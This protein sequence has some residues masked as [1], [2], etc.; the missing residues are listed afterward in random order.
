MS[1]QPPKRTLAQEI[2]KRKTQA[3]LRDLETKRASSSARTT[4]PVQRLSPA[5]TTPK[6]VAPAGFI[7][8][9][10]KPTQTVPPQPKTRRARREQAILVVSGMLV[11]LVCLGTAIAA[12][13]QPASP[14]PTFVPLPTTDAMNVIDY[15]RRVGVPVSNVQ[16]MQVPNEAWNANQQIQF[17]VRRQNDT[18]HFIV[19]S[20]PS[21]AQ[22]SADAFRAANSE[23]FKAWSRIQ[24][25]NVLVLVSPDT[26]EG[27]RAAVASHLTQYLIAPYRSFIPTATWSP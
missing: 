5:P 14:T 16:T 8:Q 18:G 3:M 21:P 2:K 1:N 4:E 26:V 20:Y 13:S 6:C 17:T 11:L 12:T 7:N 9:R 19:L 22:A 23:R 10:I 27:L 24:M 15:L 25:A